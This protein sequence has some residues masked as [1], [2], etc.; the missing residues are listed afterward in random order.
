[1][2]LNRAYLDPRRP[3]TAGRSGMEEGLPPYTPELP[4][5][6]VNVVNYNQSLL[7]VRDIVSSPSGLESTCLVF[8]HGLGESQT[9][10]M[11][12]GAG[13]RGVMT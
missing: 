1:M 12:I 10:D 8:V 9:F 3:L 2:T 11:I 7:N 5:P 13:L 6:T 4:L